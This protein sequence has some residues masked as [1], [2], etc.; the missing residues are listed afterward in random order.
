[1]LYK[2]PVS[3]SRMSDSGLD[4]SDR[5]SLSS[6]DAFD[7]LDILESPE[8]QTKVT[9]VRNAVKDWKVREFNKTTEKNSNPKG[10]VL[11]REYVAKSARL[12][13][14]LV[15]YLKTSQNKDQ[16][17]KDTL[18][19]NIIMAIGVPG[20]LS[21][22]LKTILESLLE[23]DLVELPYTIEPNV[24]NTY[25]KDGLQAQQDFPEEE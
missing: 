16:N 21:Y 1:M 2:N 12:F 22:Q 9:N 25:A 24:V 18:Y 7:T 17:M 5:D 15:N 20:S 23:R 10:L 19:V 8:E 14:D 11:L 13:Y 3:T 4:D 6:I